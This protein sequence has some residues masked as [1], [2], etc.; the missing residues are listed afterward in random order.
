MKSFIKTLTC[1]AVLGAAGGAHAAPVLFSN[2]KFET[3]NG[4][5]WF[6]EGQNGYTI[7]YPATGGSTL[8]GDSPSGYAQINGF[9]ASQT[10]YAV[11]VANANTFIPLSDLGMTAGNG[12]TFSQDMKIFAGNKIGGIKLEWLGGSQPPTPE[13]YPAIINGGTDWAT[14]N[15]NFIIPTGVTALKVV[16]L[17]APN[18]TVGIDNVRFESVP[19][20][21]APLPPP[22]PTDLVHENLFDVEGTN[23]GPP[24]GGGAGITSSRTWSSSQ[25]NPPGSTIL[26]VANPAGAPAA[27]S[28]TYT[29]PDINFGD[30]PVEISFDAR[31][32]SEFPG[33]ALHVRYNGNFIGAIQGSFNPGSF[34]KYT[35]KFNLNQGFTSSTFNLQFEFAMGAVAGSGGSIAIDNIRI[36]TNLPESAAPTTASIESGKLVSW[37]VENPGNSYQPQESTNNVDWT[38]LG[39]PISNPNVFSVFDST[40]SPFYRVRE[41]SPDIL[42]NSVYNPGFE[43]AGTEP[44]PADGWNIINQTNGTVAVAESFTGGYIANGGSKMLVLEVHTPSGASGPG[45]AEIRSSQLPVTG[46]QTYNFSFFAANVIK[47]GVSGEPQ[48]SFRF[49]DVFG[50]EMEADTIVRNF[51]SVGTEWTKVEST[52][53]VPDDAI[54]VRV[55]FAIATGPFPDL[56]YISLIDD[57]SLDTGVIVTPSQTTTIAAVAQPAVKISWKTVTGRDYQL[58]SSVNLTGWDNFGDSVAG[59]GSVVSVTDL[60][61]IP[62]KFYRVEET[63]P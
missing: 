62:S 40:S 26:T 15:F 16:P 4:A 63:T 22:P 14:Y 30:G 47:S 11:L 2:G 28:F 6:F 19:Y 50:A 44:S 52:V 39:T 61:T 8:L 57:V 1:C 59:D 20:Y 29:A 35:Q 23:W 34:T 48:Y 58:K 5:N 37:E 51:L 3:P 7:E 49:V 25:G 41:T 21:V 13:T 9:T 60:I 42:D 18:S 24:A 55:G 54:G 31:L 46:G 27:V 10:F 36:L 32:L 43:I 56:D 12:Y 45:A 33:T 38:N 53:V 17:W